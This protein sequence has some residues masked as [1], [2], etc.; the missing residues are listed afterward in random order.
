L[1]G[2]SLSIPSTV[3]RASHYDADRRQLL[4]I[5]QTGRRYLY[6]DVPPETYVGLRAAH[7]RGAF[8]NEHI[9]DHYEFRYVDEVD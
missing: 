2:R 3:I 7:S 4:I 1:G 5:F 9:R 8:F 6:F